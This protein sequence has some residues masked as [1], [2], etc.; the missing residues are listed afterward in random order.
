MPPVTGAD[1]TTESLTLNSTEPL[2]QTVLVTFAFNST[3]SLYGPVPD[4]TVVV[5]GALTVSLNEFLVVAPAILVPLTVTV[6][7][8]TGKSDREGG[9]LVTKPQL[10]L[11]VGA[12]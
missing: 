6:V 4:A 3:C 11:K 2:G 9:S 10:P 1:P 5:V 12:G 8:P 7:V